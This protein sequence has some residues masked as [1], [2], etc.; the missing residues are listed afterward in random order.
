MRKPYFVARLKC[1]YIKNSKRQEIRLDPDKADAFELWHRMIAAR[2]H[3]SVSVPA[4]NGDRCVAGWRRSASR[5]TIARAY[6]YRN[7]IQSLLPSNKTPKAYRR[8]RS[9]N[10]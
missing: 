1:W 6:R 3:G 8:S 10:V 2:G 5:V 7:G 9:E 4:F